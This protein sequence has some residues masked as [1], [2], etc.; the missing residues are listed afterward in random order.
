LSCELGV[1]LSKLND[2]DN[3]LRA[4]T[5]SLKL[6]PTD[7]MALLNYAIF[8]VNAGESQ[9]KIGPT[10][11]QFHQYYIQRAT[12]TNHRELDTS[13]LDIALKLGP[14]PLP[15]QLFAIKPSSTDVQHEG[16]TVPSSSTSIFSP[17][18]PHEAK[19]NDED[20]PKHPPQEIPVVKTKI[21][22][23]GRHK[24]RRT[25]HQVTASAEA[26]PVQDEEQQETTI[27]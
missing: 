27:F 25:K 14:P 10:L 7:P 9:S 11:Q 2:P 6:D 22:D 23:D 15:S 3:A 24:Q 13:M 16:E 8:Q 4:Y 12:S 18:N 21:Y 19:S 5:Y 26:E 20:A 1:A 17:R